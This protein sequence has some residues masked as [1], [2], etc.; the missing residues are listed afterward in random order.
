[1]IYADN[2][3]TTKV[4]EV[5]FEAMKPF[6]LN[7]YGNPSSIYSFA[8][9]ARKAVENARKMIAMSIGA[10][11]EEIYFTSGGTESDNWALKGTAFANQ[12]EGR[13]IVVSMIEHQAIL[14]ACKTLESHGYA[15]TYAPVNKEGFVESEVLKESLR[16]DTILVSVMMANNEI[17]TIQKIQEFAS[18]LKPRGIVF[19]TDAVQAVG[20]IPIDVNSMGLDLLSASGHKFNGPKGVGFLY[21]KTGTPIDAFID[22]G[23]Q[24]MRKRAGT[25][26]VAGIVGMAY[27]LHNNLAQMEDNMRHLKEL[28]DYTFSQLKACIPDVLI[29]G[30][31]T[32]RL[33]GNVNI[34]LRNANSEGLVH[35]LDI[36]EKICVSAGSACS[37]SEIEISNVIR[38][39]AVPE[40]YALGT[41]RITYGKENTMDEADKIVETIADLYKTVYCG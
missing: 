11:P 20:H 7:N 1:M 18:I 23:G 28:Q 15:V 39:I 14:Q 40:E 37:S 8:K 17:G 13:H 41:L 36:K 21:I 22:G 9:K 30:S 10:L 35:M 25:E 27:A 12:N 31:M 24:E 29:N 19:H 38:A 2:A 16:E 33:P 4:D 3:A 6:L 32:N 34:S 26:N 5:A